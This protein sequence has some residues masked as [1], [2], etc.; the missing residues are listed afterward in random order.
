MEEEKAA[1]SLSNFASWRQEKE[2]FEE[3]NSSF[4][5]TDIDGI[6]VKRLFKGSPRDKSVDENAG[7][8]ITSGMGAKEGR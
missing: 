2:E 1:P 5:G 4:L 3:A 7:H 6:A 8:S